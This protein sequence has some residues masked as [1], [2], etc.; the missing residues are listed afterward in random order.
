METKKSYKIN[1]LLLNLKS[2][3]L[4]E[5]NFILKTIRVEE[6]TMIKGKNLLN[7]SILYF[8]KIMIKLMANNAK[9]GLGSPIK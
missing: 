5:I 2:L 3:N 8:K 4:N 9:P 7:T 6:I 1:L